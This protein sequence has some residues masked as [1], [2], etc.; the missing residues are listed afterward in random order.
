MAAHG[1]PG[2]I[3]ADVITDILANGQ[4]SRLVRDVVMAGD[5]ISAA[6][7]SIIGSDEPGLLLVSANLRDNNADAIERAELLIWDQ[8]DRL[9]S[10]KASVSELKRCTARF[11]S[12]N[13]FGQMSYVACAEEIAQ[14]E[15]QGADINARVDNYRSVT[16]EQIRDC[17]AEILRRDRCS[18]LIYTPSGD[19]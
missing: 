15:M 18:T 9:V 2:Y 17:A 1:A 12:L 5:V 10:D 3:E 4:A 6:D 7:A 19:E 11:A 13:A 16:P 8:I 14:A